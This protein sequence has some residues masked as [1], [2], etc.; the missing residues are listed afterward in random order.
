MSDTNI[1]ASLN[2]IRSDILAIRAQ[3][4]AS[5]GDITARINTLQIEL[6]NKIPAND[7]PVKVAKVLEV[8][9]SETKTIKKKQASEDE[10]QVSYGNSLHYFKAYYSKYSIDQ[11]AAKTTEGEDFLKPLKNI[12]V[13]GKNIELYAKE[14]TI[15]DKYKDKKVDFDETFYK[16]V[17]EVIWANFDPK[18]KS[19]YKSMYDLYK[20]SA[21]SEVT[22]QTSVTSPNVKQN[23]TNAIPI[24]PH[25]ILPINRISTKASVVIDE[26]VTEEVNESYA[27][28]SD[29]EFMSD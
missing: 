4:D 16:R 14:T 2:Q 25:Q 20:N 12:D 26:E 24:T 27:M 17:G 23:K 21:V 19:T 11:V 6:L 29:E 15:N 22:S 1:L 3:I 7:K 18:V 13:S 8:K 10:K 9:T 28:L 5:N